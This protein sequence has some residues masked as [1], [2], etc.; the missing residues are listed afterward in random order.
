MAI[1][2][3]RLAVFGT[4]APIGK[5]GPAAMP[6]EYPL[7]QYGYGQTL[8]SDHRM[9]EEW[10]EAITEAMKRAAY[11]KMKGLSSGKERR[12]QGDL[13]TKRLTSYHHE[14][15]QRLVQNDDRFRARARERRTRRPKDSNGELTPANDA[16]Y[17]AEVQEIQ[18]VFEQRMTETQRASTLLHFHKW[19]ADHLQLRAQLS[20]DQAM[21]NAYER[22]DMRHAG[23]TWAT[24]SLKRQ[25]ARL[26]YAK[27]IR[28]DHHPSDDDDDDD[29]AVP[30]RQDKILRAKERAYARK[31]PLPSVAQQKAGFGPSPPSAHQIALLPAALVEKVVH[32]A[33]SAWRQLEHGA[34]AAAAA[35]SVVLLA[36]RQQQR[37]AAKSDPAVAAA[38]A[39]V[40][41]GRG[42]GRGWAPSELRAAE[43]W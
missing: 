16:D 43:A 42:R 4:A 31:R 6:I 1:V 29:A 36:W 21:I 38:A 17:E 28:T 7:D 13:F 10:I 25:I 34:A 39:A 23:W 26:R 40:R 19:E 33:R 12:E 35:T 24:R 22:H 9:G 27:K 41:R 3:C 30:L 11:R 37:G 18:R 2:S 5:K 32:A 20:R 15:K 8:E 14:R